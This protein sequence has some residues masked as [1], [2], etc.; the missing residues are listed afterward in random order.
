MKNALKVISLYLYFL[1]MMLL[2]A[3][4]KDR[5][6]VVIHSKIQKYK[7][8]VTDKNRNLDTDNDGWI[9]WYILM[10]DTG[11]S[12]RYSYVVSDSPAINYSSAL[13]T[14]TETLP[15]E[16]EG[17]KAVSEEEVEAEVEAEAETEAESESNSESDSNSDSDSSS[18]SSS[19]SGS[20]SGGGDGGGDGGGEVI[21]E[22]INLN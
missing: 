4:C 18:D 21:R 9:F 14:K 10:S 22:L 19:D 17:E 8:A 7:I 13:W 20:D 16:L 1:G 12:S 2:V 15:Q 3:S 11:S 6:T 5:G